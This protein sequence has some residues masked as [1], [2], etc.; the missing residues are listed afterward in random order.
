MAL[1]VERAFER[2]TTVQ[3][4]PINL[5]LSFA[6]GTHEGDS[7][8]ESRYC[9]YERTV[10]DSLKFTFQGSGHDHLSANLL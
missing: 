3:K 4:Y 10:D 6:E 7:P 2:E 9:L 1:K 8:C 5:C